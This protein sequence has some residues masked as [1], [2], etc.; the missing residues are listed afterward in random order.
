MVLSG[1]ENKF[2]RWFLAVRL[3]PVI[4]IVITLKIIIHSLGLETLSLNALFT[5][6]IAATT[7]LLGFLITG[8]LTDYKESEKLPGEMASSLAV[9][10][11]ETSIIAKSKESKEASDFL[12]YQIEF[13]ESL[14]NWFFKKERT[15]NV[16]NK[17]DGMN[18][19]FMKLESQ[20]QAGFILRMKQEQSALRKGITRINTIRETGFVGT[21]YVIAEIL[22]TF[23]VIGLLI[24]KLEPFYE[25]LFFISL[26]TFLVWYMIFLI[27]DLDDPFDY[28]MY[29]EGGTEVSL[30]PLHDYETRLRDNIKVLKI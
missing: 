18:E 21:A 20:T 8:V 28:D 2:G 19:Y 26:V 5:S 23:V 25:S 24:I 10:Y 30:K 9:L 1:F 16:M 6:L 17:L 13:I 14:N 11:D 22:A 3:I 12:R 29:G 15:N 27:R 4:I 7:F